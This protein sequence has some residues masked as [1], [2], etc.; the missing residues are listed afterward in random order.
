M[1]TAMKW[2]KTVEADGSGERLDIFLT[3]QI[4]EMTRSHIAKLLRQGAATVN[5]KVAATHRFLKT[6][7]AIEFDDAFV[8]VN[9]KAPGLAGMTKGTELA[10]L[11]IIDETPDYLV[12]DKPAGLIVHPDTKQKDGTLVDLLV[13]HDPKIG[14]LGE[15]P[16]RAGIV[17]RLDRE[18]SGLMVIPRTQD[19]FDDLKKQFATHS[20]D[21]RYVALVYGEV[22][23]DEGEIK[24][25]IARSKTKNRM[26][27]IPEHEIE[28]GKAAWTHYKIV[29]RYHNA[30]L[31]ELTIL[32]GRTHQIRAHLLAF[33]HP[34]IGDPL[35]K[36]RDEDRKLKAPRIMLQ[37]IHMSFKDPTTDETKTYDIDPVPE[38]NAI[39]KTLK[40]K[41]E[42]KIV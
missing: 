26:A 8:R 31:L 7:D 2:T 17:H 35:Y 24:F 37:S 30:T 36:R 23:L 12:I 38:F 22:G 32:S 1:M 21:K 27:A 15:D 42:Q 9:A 10:P 28:S 29:R 3:S 4:P 18:V 25:R 6:G 39:T 40:T 14:R 33:N 34:V 41:T 11:K 16:A 19:A 5:G 20:V 13:A